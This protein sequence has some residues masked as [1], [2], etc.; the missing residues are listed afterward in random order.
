MRLFHGMHLLVGFWILAFTSLA[1]AQPPYRM[2]GRVSDADTKQPV[3]NARVQV[4]LASEAAPANRIRESTTDRSGQYS[5]ELP[6]G[7]ARQW[8]ILP[9]DGYCMVKGNML[10]SFATTEDRPVFIK[11]YQLRQAIPIRLAVRYPDG[12]GDPPTTFVSLS[13]Q[14]EHDYIYG[15]RKLAT[16]GIATISL[17]SLVGKF[18]VRCEDTHRTLSAPA[19]CAVD[20]GKG[21]DPHNVLPNVMCDDEGL[22]IVQ[23][24]KGCIASFQSC[25]PLIRDRRLTIVVTMKVIRPDEQS[26]QVRGR[27][28]DTRANGIE[29]AMVRVAFYSP[30]GSSADSGWTAMTGD[31]GSFS[32]EIPHLGADQKIGFILTREGLGAKDT[33]PLERDA[34]SAA[35]N[36]MLVDTITMETACSI[37]VRVVGPSG[38]PLH[39]AV[40]EPMR[41]YAS[42][43]RIARTG[44]TGECLLT[45]LAPG[46]MPFSIRFGRLENYTQ[47]PLEPGDNGTTV[48][49][50]IDTR[51]RTSFFWAST[52]PGQRRLSSSD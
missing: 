46:R 42:R 10:D 17:P 31:D 49:K 28:V 26:L 27:V 36:T 24:T 38:Q 51:T 37:R 21:F 8:A 47:I 16:D 14:S 7:H 45:D 43:T 34:S 2:Q 30:D 39:G 9:P 32:L 25:E 23:D 41:D 35:G 3:A 48:L 15:V 6:A 20:F 11:N 1:G 19:G 50:A 44:T 4:F 18:D 40:V 12:V 33:G 29:R 13:Q 5:I 52:R 22:L